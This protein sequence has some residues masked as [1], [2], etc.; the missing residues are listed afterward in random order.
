MSDWKF[1]VTEKVQKFLKS[2]SKNDKTKVESIFLL[3]TEYGM[4]LPVK[5]M[6]RITGTENLWELRAKRI[7]IFFYMR[8]NTGIGVH[9][10]IKKSQKTPKY[11]I[12]ISVSRIKTLKE[13]LL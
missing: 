11:D 2:L 6:K 9:G 13:E 8:E 1:F 5:Y 10:I 7:R 12:E 3:F 4:A